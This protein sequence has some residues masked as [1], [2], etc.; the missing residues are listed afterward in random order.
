MKRKLNFEVI[1]SVIGLALYAFS[2]F[3]DI[4][5]SIYS[6]ELAAIIIGIFTLV[7][8]IHKNTPITDYSNKL[9]SIANKV[10]H[11]LVLLAFILLLICQFTFLRIPHF[12][13]SYI[14][15]LQLLLFLVMLVKEDEFFKRN[16]VIE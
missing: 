7:L 4:F 14:R 16:T 8:L 10:S 15:G 11:P 1:L 6:E 13:E 9:R 12:G 5:F 2:A 3:R